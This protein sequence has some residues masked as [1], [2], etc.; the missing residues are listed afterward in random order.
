MDILLRKENLHMKLTPYK[1]LAT[2]LDNGMIQFVPSVPIAH[3]IQDYVT[4]AEYL[5]LPD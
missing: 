3:L 1:V 2:G 4:L 5:K